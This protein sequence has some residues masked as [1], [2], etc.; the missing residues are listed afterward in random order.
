MPSGLPCTQGRC[1]YRCVLVQI[2]A[3]VSVGMRVCVYTCEHVLLFVKIREYTSSVCELACLCLVCVCT[4]ALASVR[5]ITA[6]HAPPGVFTHIYKHIHRCTHTY[7]R[8]R[9]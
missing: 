4:N 8:A 2:L 6:L 9:T 5:I 7:I 1:V 3:W